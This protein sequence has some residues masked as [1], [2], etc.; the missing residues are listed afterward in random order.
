M[1]CQLRLSG[2]HLV[3]RRLPHGSVWTRPPRWGR[4]VSECAPTPRGPS[5][6]Q[7]R[8]P[9]EAAG[10]SKMSPGDTRLGGLTPNP[11]A[12]RPLLEDHEGSTGISCVNRHRYNSK[13]WRDIHQKRMSRLQVQLPAVGELHLPVPP[14]KDGH[15]VALHHAAVVRPGGRDVRSTA[16]VAR[17]RSAWQGRL[18]SQF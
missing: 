8:P 1:Q 7:G 9:V 2:M 15:R 6:R 10:A 4:G 16:P 14:A 17:K 18:L 3:E 5:G 11:D 12:S 13:F